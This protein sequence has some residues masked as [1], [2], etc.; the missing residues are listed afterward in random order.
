A[1]H[2]TPSGAS[3]TGEAEDFVSGQPLAVTDVVINPKDG[4]MYFA[5]GGRNTQSALY[6]VTY[7]GSEST[8]ESK[9]DSRFAENRALRHKLESFHGRKDAKAVEAVWSYLGDRDRA[10]R[11]AAR[12]ALEWQDAAQWR[13]RALA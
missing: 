2:L 9:S 3:Y 7:T 5:V 4:A 12:I 8:A 13:E 10:L 6:R 1:V 11:Y